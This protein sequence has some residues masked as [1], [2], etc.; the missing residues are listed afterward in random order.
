MSAFKVANDQFNESEDRYRA[1]F[2]DAL[3]GILHS[4]QDGRP[5][6]IHCAMAQIFGYE[7]PEQLLADLFSR[8][9]PVL[10]DPNIWAEWETSTKE[11]DVRYGIRKRIGCPNGDTKWVR[12]NVRA[13]RNGGR[14]TRFEGSVEDIT[15]RRR[16]EA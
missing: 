7:S 9:S 14:I 3:L 6:R 8:K 11:G 15:D 4:S 16:I 2:E 13:V 1:I 10:I 12:L 5:L